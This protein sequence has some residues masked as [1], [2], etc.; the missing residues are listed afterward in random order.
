MAVANVPDETEFGGYDFQFTDSVPQRLYCNICARVLHDPHLTEC[1]GQ[2]F[3]VSCLEHWFKAQKKTTCPHCR[4][5]KFKHILSKP[6]KREID[7]LEIQCIKQ[8]VGCQWMGELSSLQAHLNSDKG[9]EY[10]DVQCSNNCGAMMM[11]K[12]LEAHLAQQ[13]PL[14]KI[15]CQYCHYE[16]TYQTITTQHYDECPFCLL[17]CPNKCGTTGILRAAM[18]NHLSRCVLEPVEC[19]FHEAGCT[20]QIL[21]REFDVH[22]SENQQH[23]LLVLLEAFQETKKELSESQRQLGECQKELGECQRK[24]DECLRKM[25]VNRRE[26]REN[27]T[28]LSKCHKELDEKLH[29]TT[30]KLLD[31]RQEL[32]GSKAKQAEKKI[33]KH[34]GDEV[35]F[36]MNNF[37]LYK[38]T[39]KVWHSPAFYYRT[40]YKLCLAVYANGKGAGAGTHVSVELMQMRGEHDHKLKWGEQHHFRIRQNIS[41][42]MMAQGKEVRAQDQKFSLERHLCS[43]CFSRLPPHGELRVCYSTMEGRT[44][45]S[46]DKFIDHQSAEQLMVFND[47]I[48]LR[49]T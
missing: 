30:A 9:C 40:G 3:C 10:A 11:R 35:T 1:C 42:Q 49:V 43:Q 41:I 12:E 39:G 27:Q 16:D 38:Q 28:E 36:R 14:R 5:K 29:N 32:E 34:L 25:G 17:P 24:V 37:S 13:C 21:R 46:K 8:G 44:H 26:L 20:V 7:E 22:M 6:L 19:P 48:V 15:Q 45:I 33:L 2:H 18:A 47:T 23:H 31:T 4:Q